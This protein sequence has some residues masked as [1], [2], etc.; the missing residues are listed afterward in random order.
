[1]YV[2]FGIMPDIVTKALAFFPMSQGSAWMRKVFTADAVNAAFTGLPKEAIKEYYKITGVEINFGDF[3][4]TP[5]MQFA[6]L[7]VSGILF[8]ILSVVMMSKK[9]V[10]DR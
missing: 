4:F 2:P 9:N 10:R 3:V 5:W 6:L 1:M 7:F 8:M